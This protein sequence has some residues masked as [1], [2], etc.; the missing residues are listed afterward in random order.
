MN[1]QETIFV[2]A[3]HLLTVA[4]TDVPVYKRI[5]VDSNG[6]VRKYEKN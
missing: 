3:Y 6:H 2:I 1:T 4:C 5:C